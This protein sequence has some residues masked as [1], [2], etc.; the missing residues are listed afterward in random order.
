MPIHKSNDTALFKNYR[1]LGLSEALRKIFEAFI[2]LAMDDLFITEDYHYG[3]K[4]N[5]S[6]SDAA[7]DLDQKM[8]ELREQG[9]LQDY[10]LFKLDIQSAFD[11]IDHGCLKEFMETFIANP[12]FPILCC[13]CY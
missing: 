5:Y 1:P 8:K 10:V 4:K 12:F 2:S 3:Y 7:F 9:V 11:R 6:T 13:H